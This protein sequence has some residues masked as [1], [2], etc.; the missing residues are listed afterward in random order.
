MNYPHLTFKTPNLND[1]IN[2]KD[3]ALELEKQLNQ[4]INQINNKLLS[5]EQ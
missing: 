5:N 3:K 2:L 4:V 1:L